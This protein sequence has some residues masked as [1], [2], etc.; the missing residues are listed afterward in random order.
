[1]EEDKDLSSYFDLYGLP[2]EIIGIV[3]QKCNFLDIS[4]IIKTC[5]RFKFIINK[6]RNSLSKASLKHF[7]IEHRLIFNNNVVKDDYKVVIHYVA[8]IGTENKRNFSK[9]F[10]KIN[11]KESEIALFINSFTWEDVENVHVILMK[12]SNV[13][14]LLTSRLINFKNHNIKTLYLHVEGFDMRNSINNFILSLRSVKDLFINKLCLCNEKG[15]FQ[16]EINISNLK[17]IEI[18]ECCC[19]K[20]INEQF[21]LPLY[22]QNKGG[23]N[24][25]LRVNE[26]DFK[27]KLINAA[28]DQYVKMDGKDYKKD[29]IAIT[30][31]NPMIF[32]HIDAIMSKNG[33]RYEPNF[34]EQ[35]T[36]CTFVHLFIAKNNNDFW[37]IIENPK[38]PYLI[39]SIVAIYRTRISQCSIWNR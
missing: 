27:T 22:H 8:E 39:V 33:L 35:S 34:E 10:S 3:F 28:V 17:R 36:S 26:S 1:M 5:K 30:D 19:T 13:L 31:L 29:L 38:K 11:C 9:T 18:L 16:G 25:V 23:F 15:G 4:S 37:N 24:M 14:N 2:D 12:K 32:Y 6:N 20:F 7:Q 21:A